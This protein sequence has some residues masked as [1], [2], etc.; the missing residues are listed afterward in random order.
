V[1]VESRMH[2]DTTRSLVAAYKPYV[3]YQ[4][5]TTRPIAVIELTRQDQPESGVDAPA[6]RT[7]EL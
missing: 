7:G 1:T 4:Q 3:R 6:A 5:R 2:A